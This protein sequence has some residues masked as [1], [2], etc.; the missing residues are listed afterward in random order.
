MLAGLDLETWLSIVE[1]REGPAAMA[2][3]DVTLELNLDPSFEFSRLGLLMPLLASLAG[4]VG[5]SRSG[6]GLG[7][8]L[9]GILK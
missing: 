8:L 9:K 2:L 7:L 6:R 1:P 4:G 5:V 3:E